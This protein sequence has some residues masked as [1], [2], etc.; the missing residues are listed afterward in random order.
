MPKDGRGFVTSFEY[1]LANKLT[2]RIDHGGRSGKAGNYVY[3]QA[4]VE[5]YTYTGSGQMKTKIDRNGNLTSY[6]YDA[7]GRLLSQTVTGAELVPKDNQI[8]YTY[9]NNGNQLSMKDGTGL[10]SRTYFKPGHHEVRS[11]HGDKYVPIRPNDRAHSWIC[12]RSHDRCQRQRDDE[13][14][15]QNE[16][17]VPSQ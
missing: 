11:W 6:V 7:H 12:L 2:K 3:N 5:S 13:D 10:T 1:N 14:L 4:K 16:P 9:D 15:R 17:L 8:F